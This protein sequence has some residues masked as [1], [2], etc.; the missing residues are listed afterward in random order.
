M[1]RHAGGLAQGLGR[2]ALAETFIGDDV[3]GNRGKH[4]FDGAVRIVVGCRGII[5][6]DHLEI[7][8]T[9]IPRGIRG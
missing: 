7:T 4:P 2:I 1:R 9:N 5:A 6:D 8:G 3:A